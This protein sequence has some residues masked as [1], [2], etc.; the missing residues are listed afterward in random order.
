M[1]QILGAAIRTSHC[2]PNSQCCRS[3]GKNGSNLVRD[4]STGCSGHGKSGWVRLE[5]G[6]GHVRYIHLIS[7]RLTTFLTTNYFI[8]PHSENRILGGS[9]WRE[10]Y[11]QGSSVS[12]NEWSDAVFSDPCLLRGSHRSAHQVERALSCQRDRTS[13]NQS[14]PFTDRI[15]LITDLVHEQEKVSVARV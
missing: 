14:A 5:G 4:A 6:L 13:R 9:K 12:S 2:I 15:I 8:V 7:L 10:G 11:T 3:A 1:D